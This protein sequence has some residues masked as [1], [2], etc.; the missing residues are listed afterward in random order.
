MDSQAPREP[1][2]VGGA[3]VQT[4]AAHV[5]PK[6]RRGVLVGGLGALSAIAL[7]HPTRAVDLPESSRKAVPS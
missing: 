4:S 6:T 2:R 1:E 3:R 5:A 7:L